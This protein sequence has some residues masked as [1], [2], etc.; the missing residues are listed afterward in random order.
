MQSVSI[1][2]AYSFRC[3]QYIF[4]D[5]YNLIKLYTP[6]LQN[7]KFSAKFRQN[8]ST[9]KLECVTKSTNCCYMKI[10]LLQNTATI[11]FNSL[12]NCRSIKS[13]KRRYRLIG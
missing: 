10:N 2:L 12:F 11:K 9:S 1:I 6:Y 5:S 13:D 7:Q 3:L 8:E 4:K